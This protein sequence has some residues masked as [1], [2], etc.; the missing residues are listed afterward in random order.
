MYYTEGDFEFDCEGEE[1]LNVADKP[2][3]VMDKLYISSY[4]AVQNK[5]LLQCL[6]ISH[7]VNLTGKRCCF[8]MVLESISSLNLFRRLLLPQC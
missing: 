3:K 6:K 2:D 7:I 8:P 5:K 1:E 4:E